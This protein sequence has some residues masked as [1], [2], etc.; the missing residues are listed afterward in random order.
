MATLQLDVDLRPRLLG[1]VSRRDQAVVCE[2]E[3]DDQKDDDR[4]DNPA[5]DA[6]VVLL[7][8]AC[9]R[10]CQRVFLSIFLCLCLRIFLRRFL[11]TEPNPAPRR[12]LTVEVTN[13][14][15]AWRSYRKPLGLR[16]GPK[17]DGDV[18]QRRSRRAA[19]AH[20]QVPGEG[21]QAPPRRVGGSDLSR[22]DIPALRR[23]WLS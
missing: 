6:H 2:D 10:L 11:I 14:P 22:L 19:A 18:L 23:A 13:R 8:Q 15:K 1:P 21:S 3:P 12:V 5:T 7:A 4:D 9:A 16:S 20:S 17:L